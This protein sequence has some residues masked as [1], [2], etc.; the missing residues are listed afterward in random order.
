[1][2]LLLINAFL[3]LLASFI[4]FTIYEELSMFP[5]V[6]RI[7]AALIFTYFILF[8]LF[9]AIDLV[10]RLILRKAPDLLEPGTFY[11]TIWGIGALA[12][13]NCLHLLRGISLIA[14]QSNL[15]WRLLGLTHGKRFVVISSRINDPSRVKIGHNV[16]VG[17]DATLGNRYHPFRGKVDRRPITIGNDCLIGG[18]AVIQNGVEIGDR[19]TIAVLS[20]VASGATLESGW[21]YGGV[22]AEKIRPLEAGRGGASPSLQSK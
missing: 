9:L 12:R 5:L 2:L 11:R 13:E 15:T 18:R 3:L 10:S 21:I 8:F 6:L 4:A 7:P 14:G 19:V 1:M 22:P 20:A 16:L 17:T